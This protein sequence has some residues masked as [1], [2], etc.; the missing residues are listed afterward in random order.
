MIF[1]LSLSALVVIILLIFKQFSLVLPL[2]AG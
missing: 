2:S 1:L